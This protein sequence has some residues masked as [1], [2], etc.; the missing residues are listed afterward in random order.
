MGGPS[1]VSA[2]YPGCSQG[3]ST[4][5]VRMWRSPRLVKPLVV[6][7]LPV[8][9]GCS[10]LESWSLIL[11]MH[12][13]I[14]SLRCKGMPR[15]F[16]GPLGGGSP[17]GHCACKFQWLQSSWIPISGALVQWDCNILGAP[18]CARVQKIPPGRKLG[19]SYDIAFT[20]H[21]RMTSADQYLQTDA[22]SPLDSFLAVYGRRVS[23][24]SVT[25]HGQK[26][27][28]VVILL[29]V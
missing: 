26:Q 17:F 27:K 19:Q 24:V 8:A 1:G 6:N 29:F 25:H 22:L 13:S 23:P 10:Q 7:S 3:L 16:L 15:R 21:S 5:T 20:H 28:L 11:C 14:V 12:R 18:P 2:E 4:L 9:A